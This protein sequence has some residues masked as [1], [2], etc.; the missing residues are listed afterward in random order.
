M[1]CTDLNEIP[2]GSPEI[3]AVWRAVAGLGAR[4]VTVTAAEPGHGASTVALALA[5][6]AAAASSRERGA[7]LVDANRRKPGFTALADPEPGQPADIGGGLWLLASP[8]PGQEKAWSER[9]SLAEL[10]AGW[11]AEYGMVVLDGAPMLSR[12]AEPVSGAAAAAAADAVFLVSMSG[13]NPANRV[14]EAVAAISRAGAR[15]TGV[16]MNDMREPPLLMELERELC[17][18]ETVWPWLARRLRRFL[19]RSALL[20]VRI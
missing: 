19:G 6:R 7:L 14:G 15:L 12:E 5:R 10:C 3:E 4:S 8:A 13:Q 17:R 20:S 11:S 1:E 16:V 9:D 18:V 2:T